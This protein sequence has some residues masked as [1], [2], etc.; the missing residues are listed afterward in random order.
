MINKVI[1]N[2]LEKD[3]RVA[4]PEIGTLVRNDKGETLFVSVMK[5]DDGALA[6][7]IGREIGVGDEIARQVMGEYIGAIR[8]RLT[9]SGKYVIEGIGVLTTDVNGMLTFVA[10]GAPD[11]GAPQVQAVIE[12]EPG[13]SCTVKTEKIMSSPIEEMIKIECVRKPEPVQESVPQPASVP[14]PQPEQTAPKQ[15]Q[16]EAAAPQPHEHSERFNEVFETGKRLCDVDPQPVKRIFDIKP[17]VT[18]NDKFVEQHTAPVHPEAVPPAA[19]AVQHAAPVVPTAE[20][21]VKAP[22]KTIT[23]EPVVKEA[24]AAEPV[25]QDQAVPELNTGESAA[26]ILASIKSSGN[27]RMD[28]LI[29]ELYRDG[30]PKT[31]RTTPPARPVPPPA[32]AAVR[33]EATTVADTQSAPVYPRRKKKKKM[34][35]VMVVSIIAIV[36]ALVVIL[37][38]FYLWKIS[39]V[40]EEVML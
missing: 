1:A 30:Q 17:A 39:L 38:S 18:T 27:G 23:A 35:A 13:V 5:T 22:E 34:D 11:A 28:S 9:E 33:R 12:P 21:A 8:S 2:C 31:P 36:L 4:I 32:P 29:D 7:E 15:E 6:A 26:A 16:S 24:A 10:E 19:P 25:S 20:S 37:Y 3:G 40:A 14:V